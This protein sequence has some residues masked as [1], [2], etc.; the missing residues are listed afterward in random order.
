MARFLSPS[1]ALLYMCLSGRMPQVCLDADMPLSHLFLPVTLFSSVK[2]PHPPLHLLSPP[3][4]PPPPCR[5]PI[6]PPCLRL[7]LSLRFVANSRL[8]SPPL[9][10]ARTLSMMLQERRPSA[11]RRRRPPPRN[12]RPSE[13]GWQ[14]RKLQHGQWRRNA[15]HKKRPPRGNAR[16]RSRQRRTRRLRRRRRERKLSDSGARRRRGIRQRKRRQRGSGLRRSARRRRKLKGSVSLRPR[17][18]PQ[19]PTR[20][21]KAA[22]SLAGRRMMSPQAHLRKLTKART[23]QLAASKPRSSQPPSSCPSLRFKCP[24]SRR[25]PRS[26]NRTRSLLRS[27]R[28]TSTPILRQLFHPLQTPKPLVCP[29]FVELRPVP[30][31]RARSRWTG[32]R[33]CSVPPSR[34][35]CKISTRSSSTSTST[36]TPSSTSQRSTPPRRCRSSTGRWCTRSPR[37]LSGA[38][39]SR[40]TCRRARSTTRCRASSSCSRR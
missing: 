19:L 6:F 26:T 34:S 13:S 29:M 12:V 1:S 24:F 14:R 31:S 5:L 38:A 27:L 9:K 4:S 2:F 35:S 15:S 16:L 23:R 8:P 22:L 40:T 10:P 39:R 25:C 11:R 21:R 28:T 33:R 37:S 30:T 32:P 36:S 18:Q 7:R 3:L 20:R 17:R